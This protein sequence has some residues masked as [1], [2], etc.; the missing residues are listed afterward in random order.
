MQVNI[1]K[2]HESSSEG[3][4]IEFSSQ[5]GVAKGLWKGSTPKISQS[6]FVEIDI[7]KILIWATDIIETDYEEYKMWSE[8]GNIFFN[9][10]MERCE[11]D[12]CLTVR[13]GDSIILIE[14][15]G[16]PYPQGSFLKIETNRILIYP[17]D[18]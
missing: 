5:Y 8:Q 13:F 1:V 17:Y 10:R 9:V 18:L 7:P 14:T 15:E 4:Y 3:I 6:Y 16:I 2:L 11:D 12:G